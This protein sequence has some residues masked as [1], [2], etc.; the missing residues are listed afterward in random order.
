[1]EEL[2]AETIR[3]RV[4]ATRFAEVNKSRATFLARC[5]HRLVADSTGTLEIQQVYPAGGYHVIVEGIETGEPL[6]ATQAVCLIY[7]IED[8]YITRFHA[9]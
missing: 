7:T 9:Y 5:R 2:C 8:E 1:M 6:G 3:H 4:R